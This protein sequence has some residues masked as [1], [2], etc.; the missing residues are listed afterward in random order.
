MLSR[1][2]FAHLAGQQVPRGWSC[3][4]TA[5]RC[6]AGRKAAAHAGSLSRHGRPAMMR[7]LQLRPR[8]SSRLASGR[9]LP[10]EITAGGVSRGPTRPTANE[11][12]ACTDKSYDKALA[13]QREL[14]AAAG[15]PECREAYERN[16]ARTPRSERDSTAPELVRDP[17]AGPRGGDPAW[18]RHRC[19]G[20]LKDARADVAY[21]KKLLAGLDAKE[22]A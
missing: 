17:D 2:K 10:S 16:L 1:K 18:T 6:A 3:R 9:R 11:H 5:A 14:L 22:T 20:R 21:R 12:A 13:L 4:P 8:A 19:G 15:W 7:A